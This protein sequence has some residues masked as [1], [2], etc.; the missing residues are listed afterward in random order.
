MYI[1]AKVD[2]AINV[3]GKPYQTALA[4]RSLIKYSG[5]HVGRIFINVEKK[6]PFGFHES[7]LKSLLSDLDVVYYTPS[8]FLGWWQIQKRN[9]VNKLLYHIPAFRY[10]IRYQYP[11]EKTSANY[12]FL[13]HND[14]VFHGDI[15]SA[16]LSKVG[17]SIAIGHVGQCWNC[18][19]H[20]VHCDGGR[21]WDYRPTMNELSTLYENWPVDRAVIW[22]FIQAEKP[23]WPLPECRLN[24]H[25]ALINM[26]VARKLTV[27]QGSLS[28]IGLMTMDTGIKWFQDVAN[29]GYKVIH[30]SFFKYS[31]HGMF[32]EAGS[33]HGALFDES[34]YKKEESLAKEML[35]SKSY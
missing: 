25:A 35:E 6:Q 16:Y 3:Y 22:G 13:S 19:A 14:M 29:A 9:W 2:I 28:P 17:D 11:W 33:G 34:L 23:S 15:L 32:N 20:K 12:L 21:Y 24:E 7:Q 27:P 1:S 26:T 18:P 4:I 31:K 30:D 8:L 10:S 5:D